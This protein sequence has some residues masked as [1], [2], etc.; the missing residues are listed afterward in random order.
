MK[1]AASAPSLACASVKPSAPFSGAPA[2]GSLG[3][4]HVVLAGLHEVFL[5]DAPVGRGH[6]RPD[7]IVGE[8][9]IGLGTNQHAVAVAVSAFPLAAQ[10]ASDAAKPRPASRDMPRARQV[11]IPFVCRLQILWVGLCRN[12]EAT[13]NPFRRGGVSPLA[14]SIPGAAVR[15]WRASDEQP[16]GP[17]PQQSQE[18]DQQ[19]RERQQREQQQRQNQ[20]PNQQPG[21]KP[22]QPQHRDE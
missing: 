21:Q 1:P 18:R 4:E 16:E 14:T 22:G 17:H 6:L 13:G 12:N 3:H 10:S 19:Q 15:E 9:T 8:V 20:Q 7:A 11:Q 5:I 2:S